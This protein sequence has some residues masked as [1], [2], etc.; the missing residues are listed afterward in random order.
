MLC[1]PAAEA[2]PAPAP[3]T[4]ALALG[5]IVGGKLVLLAGIEKGGFSRYFWICVHIYVLFIS[6]LSD[7]LC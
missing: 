2:A 1:S 3:L 7:S 5:A 6:V 4:P